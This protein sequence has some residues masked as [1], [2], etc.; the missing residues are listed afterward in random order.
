MADISS[1]DVE[2]PGDVPGQVTGN[3]QIAALEGGEK[4]VEVPGGSDGDVA[5]TGKVLGQLE[6]LISQDR[7]LIRKGRHWGI[8]R[9][10]MVDLGWG[11]GTG[12]RTEDT[13]SEAVR[14][15]SPLW[16]CGTRRGLNTL[17]RAKKASGSA[18]SIHRYFTPGDSTV[19]G[20]AG[21]TRSIELMSAASSS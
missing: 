8:R 14:G 20:P 12:Q 16:R 17:Q 4:T 3:E 18:G 13:A 10:R 6:F 15:E 11:I 5:G 7:H 1:S 19:A 2:G 21:S 9:I